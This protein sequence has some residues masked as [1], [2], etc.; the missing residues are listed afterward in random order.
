M[1]NIIEI[2]LDISK[3]ILNVSTNEELN[4][5]LNESRK[6]LFGSINEYY[7]YCNN[8][9]LKI[10]RDIFLAAV[11]EIYLGSIYWLE[12]EIILSKNFNKS[13]AFN[14]NEFIIKV[15]SDARDKLYR[16]RL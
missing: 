8:G 1:K 3:Y 4:K 2:D 16:K 13:Y 7:N 12:G 11:T 5:K 6:L 10:D 14:L 15:I 9:V